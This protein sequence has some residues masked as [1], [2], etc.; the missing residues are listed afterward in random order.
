MSRV[1]NKPIPLPTGVKV[2]V[3]GSE[4]NIE[5]PKGKAAHRLPQALAARLENNVLT[6]ENGS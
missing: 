2:A 6:L 1:G 4:L 5:G 3:K